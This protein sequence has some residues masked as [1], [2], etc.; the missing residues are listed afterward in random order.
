M[1]LTRISR[2]AP[3]S[4]SNVHNFVGGFEQFCTTQCPTSELLWLAVRIHDRIQFALIRI[5]VQPDFDHHHPT[6]QHSDA[7]IAQLVVGSGISSQFRSSSKTS[8]MVSD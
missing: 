1:Y 6:Y 8:L 4:E 7:G 2:S 3:G 5:R